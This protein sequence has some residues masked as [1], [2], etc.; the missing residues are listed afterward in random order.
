MTFWRRVAQ[1]RLLDVGAIIVAGFCVARIALVLPLRA[2]QLD[3]SHYYVSS[4][5]LLAG[6]NPYTTPLAPL[7]EQ[8][9][10]AG[11]DRIP[12][13]TNPPS[14][15]WAFA[16]FA[17][18]TPA[19]AFLVWTAFQAVCLGIL[20]W[21]TWLLLRPRLSRRGGWFLTAAVL[22]SPVLVWHFG[23]GQTQL[24]LAALTLVAYALRCRGYPL[25]ACLV[26]TLAGVLK[27]FPLVLLPWFVMAPGR[28]RSRVGRI[29]V[30]GVSTVA[31]VLITGPSRWVDYLSHAGPFLTSCVTNSLYNFSI[32]SLLTNLGSAVNGSVSP[33]LVGQGWWIA[34]VAA[35][36]LM[37]GGAYAVCWAGREDAEASFSLLSAAMLLSAP[38][39]WGHYLVFMAF[40]VAAA[41][42]RVAAQPTGKRVLTF[43]VVFLLLNN[44]YNIGRWE[45]AFLRQHLYLYI[46][47]N[48][49]PLAGLLGLAGFFVVEMLRLS[50]STS[51]E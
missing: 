16:P 2:T 40:P 6:Q 45:G 1:S 48:L 27:I 13:A 29:V 35:G 47:A 3:F 19:A 25:M 17:L 20:V 33:M 44:L 37:L 14:L 34:A 9:G 21:L 28:V 11:S 8:F 30:T 24:L 4:R 31:V 36:C 23:Y 22:A 43:G 38:I 39:S 18:L 7:Y 41:S 50:E 12:V 26:L 51:H 49:M 42:A 5:L 10:F 46:A 32:P 15:L